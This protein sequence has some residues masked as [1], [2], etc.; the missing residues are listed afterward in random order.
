MTL[1]LA[2]N[3]IGVEGCPELSKSIQDN[4]TLEDLDISNNR[5]PLAGIL[6]LAKAIRNNVALVNLNV[7]AQSCQKYINNRLLLALLKF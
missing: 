7:S 2:S 4:T 6:L 5:I 1:N 3:G